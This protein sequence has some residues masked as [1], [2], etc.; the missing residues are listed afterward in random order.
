M[1][2]SDFIAAAKNDLQH[3]YY[4]QVPLFEC[5]PDSSEQNGCKERWCKGLDSTLRADC[6]D[7]ETIQ[8]LE[9]LRSSG[10]LGQWR[11]SQLYVGPPGT[12]STVH[13]DQVDNLF[14]QVSGE[15]HFLLFE[16]EAAEGLYSFPI[17][18]PHD[19]HAMLDLEFIDDVTFPKAR[20]VLAGR[21]KAAH[22]KA[23]DCLYLP[24]HWWH[25][26][27]GGSVNGTQ[28]S[29]R[30]DEFL[31]HWSISV[32]FWFD[33]SHTVFKPEYPYPAHLELELARHAELF[34]SD[35]CGASM[36]GQVAA[37]LFRDVDGEAGCGPCDLGIAPRVNLIHEECSSS[38]ATRNFLLHRLA[39][40][41]GAKNVGRFVRAFLD[42]Q[43]FTSH[44]RHAALRAHGDARREEPR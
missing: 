2:F 44:C 14:L 12:L 6:C 31:K 29:H 42:P 33:I 5:D 43:R 20:A 13:Y 7:I 15:K 36:L 21:G 27:Q 8:L 19:R 22:L 32:N 37:E 30:E 3:H 34:L 16:P 25:H 23:G 1:S 17:C 11:R 28:L 18:H 9:W 4:L 40:L 39:L 10:G 35:A 38:L 24:T 26:V 41:L